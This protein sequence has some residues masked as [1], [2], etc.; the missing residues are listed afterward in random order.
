MKIFCTKLSK[1][2]EDIPEQELQKKR[3]KQKSEEKTKQVMKIDPAET[4]QNKNFIDFLVVDFFLNG[5]KNTLLKKLGMKKI[6]GVKK[7]TQD[8]AL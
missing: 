2:K 3:N 1:D 7:H 8:Q 5:D 6:I 4:K